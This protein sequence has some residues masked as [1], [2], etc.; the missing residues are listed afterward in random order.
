MTD[1]DDNRQ[2][3]EIAA[4]RRITEIETLFVEMSDLLAKWLREAGPAADA[5]TKQMTNK[6]NE[7]QNAHMM[8]LRAEEVFHDKFGSD[9]I[10]D[11]IDYVAAR[12]DIGRTLDRL[13]S[14]IAATEVSKRS[15]GCAD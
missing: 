5:T 7:L 6:I 14:K 8:V 13:R 15:D 1:K 3:S 2:D 11:G 4:R 9:D 12:N 10:A